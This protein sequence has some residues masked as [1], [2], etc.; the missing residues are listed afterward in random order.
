[1]KVKPLL[2]DVST[3]QGVQRDG[4]RQLA[5]FRGLAAAEPET[6][7][8]LIQCRYYSHMLGT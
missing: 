2:F 1:M 6:A 4:D 3:F 5:V 7:L 8:K